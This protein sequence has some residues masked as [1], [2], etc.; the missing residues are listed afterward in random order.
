MAPMTAGPAPVRNDST[1]PFA[2]IRSKRRTA[3]KHE[4]ERRREGDQRGQQ[5]SGHARGRVADH[6]NR[7]HDRTRGDLAERHGVEELCAGH[8]VV[9]GHR[10]VLHQRD[11]DEPAAVG[12]G[13][14]LERHP[15]QRP[16]T[17]DRR[18]VDD[19]GRKNARAE[20]GGGGRPCRRMTISVSPQAT[21]TSTRYGPMVAAA[22]PP[23]RP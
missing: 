1:A 19:D 3:D 15:G 10:V 20:P 11:D 5:S 17:A 21:S 4:G 14:D 23:T 13:T 16:E 18:H 7:L 2:R 12:E 9:G 22:A 6:R 8:P